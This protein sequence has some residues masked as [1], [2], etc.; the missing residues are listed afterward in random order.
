MREIVVSNFQIYSD[1][2]EDAFLQ[3]QEQSS[4][5]R[6]PRLDGEGWINTLDLDQKSFKSALVYIAFAGM[7][8]EAILHLLVVK[9]LGAAAYKKVDRLT[10]EKKLAALGINDDDLF[11]SLKYFRDLRRELLHEKA[12]FE[13][14]NIRTAQDE[15]VKVRA[16][17][18][19]VKVCLSDAGFNQ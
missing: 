16:T 12:Y 6:K 13:Q 10:Y 9:H 11:G 4:K 3:M 8:L 17:I 5:G 2:A 15:A 1:I 18:H 7:W 19:K 14:N